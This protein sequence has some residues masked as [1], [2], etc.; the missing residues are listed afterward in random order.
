MIKKILTNVVVKYSYLDLTNVE[1][2]DL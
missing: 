2:A 1:M